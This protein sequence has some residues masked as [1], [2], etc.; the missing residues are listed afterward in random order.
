MD[1]GTFS[2]ESVRAYKRTRK[3]AARGTRHA[4][5]WFP[6][7]LW[8]GTACT[9]RQRTSIE[10]MERGRGN[11]NP[12]QSKTPELMA[13][14]IDVGDVPFWGPKNKTLHFNPFSPKTAN[15]GPIFTGLRHHNL[16]LLLL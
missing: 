2:R 15:F 4:V 9:A 8:H 6:I 3:V 11:S 7:I 5:L 16:E 10:S 1:H 14:K 12:A 13:T